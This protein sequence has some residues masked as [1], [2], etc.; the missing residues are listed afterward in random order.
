MAA[1]GARRLL[2]MI[3]NAVSVIGIELLAAAQGCDFHA[4]LKSSRILEQV[5]ARVRAEVP[6]LNDDRHLHPDLVA[7]GRLVR[8]GDIAAIADDIL[9]TISGVRTG[10]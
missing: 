5:R 7:A 8:S 4:P 9:P 3:E 2:P 6:P 10:L 1:H